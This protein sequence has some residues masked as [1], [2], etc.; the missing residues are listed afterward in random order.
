MLF[1]LVALL[2]RSRRSPAEDFSADISIVE[3]KLYLGPGHFLWMATSACAR[4]SSAA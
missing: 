3:S 1:G 4:P 2:D